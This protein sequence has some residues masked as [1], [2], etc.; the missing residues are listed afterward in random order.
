MVFSTLLSVVG[1]AALTIS[2]VAASPIAQPRDFTHQALTA[3][4]LDGTPLPSGQFYGPNLFPYPADIR[5]AAT[6]PHPGTGS[7]YM[8]TLGCQPYY[9]IYDNGRK[10][11]V[12]GFQNENGQLGF[13]NPIGG[14]DTSPILGYGHRNVYNSTSLSFDANGRLT[15]GGKSQF[16]ACVPSPFA[17]VSQI[18]WLSDP[19]TAGALGC[20]QVEIYQVKP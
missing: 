20:T 3:K 11:F 8:Y 15:V 2:G 14:S 6:G 9:G 17:G 16:A 18:R 12:D 1:V 7:F 4:T 19:S 10:G 13:E 5:L